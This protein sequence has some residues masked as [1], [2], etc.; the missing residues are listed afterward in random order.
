MPCINTKNQ[1]YLSLTKWKREQCFYLALD[2]LIIHAQF[3]SMDTSTHIL[4]NIDCKKN[5]YP[6]KDLSFLFKLEKVQMIIW[7]ITT[8]YFKIILNVSHFYWGYLHTTIL[9]AQQSPHQVIPFWVH[10]WNWLVSFDNLITHSLWLTK[11]LL[12]PL[13]SISTL[14]LIHYIKPF[15]LFS[16]NEWF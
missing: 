10:L 16:P 1:M 8:V 7:Q 13:P 4:A 5:L 15:H 11:F 12:I 2:S 9:Q 14:K 3:S 6:K